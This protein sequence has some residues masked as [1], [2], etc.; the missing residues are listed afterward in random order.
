L[1]ASPTVMR[2]VFATEKSGVKVFRVPDGVM[3]VGGTVSVSVPA[4]RMV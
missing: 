4:V 1:L 3:I 2:M